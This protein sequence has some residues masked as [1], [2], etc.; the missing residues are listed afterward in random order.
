MP[1]VPRPRAALRHALDHLVRD[2]EDRPVAGQQIFVDRLLELLAFAEQLP[3]ATAEGDVL[4]RRQ[5][6]VAH[7]EHAVA[8]EPG[9]AQ[10]GKEFVAHRRRHVHVD[11]LRTQRGT[12][13]VY[14]NRFHALTLR[15]A[16]VWAIHRA[17]AS[18]AG[19]PHIVLHSHAH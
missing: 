9:L 1:V 18:G 5:V 2:P 16:T 15:P 13:P 17:A 4:R 11:D 7:H 8:V 12:Q 14:G 6:L 19:P 10:L 3:E